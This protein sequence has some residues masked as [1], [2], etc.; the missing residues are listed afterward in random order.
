MMILRITVS[1]TYV[2]KTLDEWVED[3]C[4]D[5]EKN[6][7]VNIEVYCEGMD[8]KEKDDFLRMNLIMV[9]EWAE[10]ISGVSTLKRG[11]PK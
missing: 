4:P 7:K 3:Y 9:R 6:L 8:Q 11:N 1:K 2:S 5:L 10:E